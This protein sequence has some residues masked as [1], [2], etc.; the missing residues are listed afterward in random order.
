MT[1]IIGIAGSVR[2]GSYNGALLRAA[3]ELAPKGCTVETASIK[4]IPLYDG[5]LEA[6][7]GIP[8]TVAELKDRIAAADG[9]LIS[10]T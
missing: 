7:E 3:T 1:T 2:T 5:D 8:K 6:V 9:L 4:D 10:D